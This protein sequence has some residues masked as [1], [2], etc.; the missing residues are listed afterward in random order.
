MRG[1]FLIDFDRFPILCAK[2]FLEADLAGPV[3]RNLLEL[4]ALLH[5][6][7]WRCLFGGRRTL[8]PGRL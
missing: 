7:G 1:H 6:F 2:V 4:V 3:V 8:F 5:A